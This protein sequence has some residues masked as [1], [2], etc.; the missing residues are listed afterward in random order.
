VIPSIAK[1]AFKAALVVAVGSG[2]LPAPL[3]AQDGADAPVTVV[4]TTDVLGGLVR[5]LV[6]DAATVTV[7]MEGGVDPH[8]WA[9]SARDTEAIFGADLV[10]ANGL[11]LEEGL[12]DVL[13]SAE[14]EG[15]SVFEATDHVAVR[16]SDPDAAAVP[17]DEVDHDGEGEHGDDDHP[18]GDPHFWLDPLAVREV[19][20]ALVTTFDGLGVD[21][22]DRGADLA[23]RL[24][25]LDADVVATLATIPPERRR[26]VTGHESLGYFAERYGFELVGAVVPGLSSQGEVSARELAALAAAVRAAGVDVVLT[27]V[28]T[29]EQIARALSAETG[30]RLVAV[31]LEQLPAD[32]SYETLIRD[33]ATT[34]ADA[35]AG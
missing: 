5:D 13:A 3:A 21:V 10:V 32:G 17:A 22:A 6:E 11:G 33:L 30:A 4:V 28:G 15:V 7:L 25:A 9:P 24:E 14:A 8:G 2:L 20:L 34:I 16:E 1:S 31:S 29:P 27:E 26:L 19:V 35:L 23:A 18:A 12:I